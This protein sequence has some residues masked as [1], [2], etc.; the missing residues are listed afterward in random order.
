MD[1]KNL[2]ATVAPWIGTAL[3]GPLGGMAV[4]AVGNALGLSEKTESSIK[5]A[6]AGVTPDQMLAIKNADQA[7]ALQMQ[8]LGFKQVSDMEAFAVADRKD[9]RD[10]QKTTRSII[11]ATL[12]VM[13]T[14][15]YFGILIGMLSGKFSIS[16]SQALLIML[17]SLSTGWGV[18]MAFWFGTTN[19]SGRKTELLAKSAPVK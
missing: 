10:M 15:G 8:A 6:L 17:G 12:S 5:A 3:G 16:D 19:D 7:F 18:V 1:W 13:I 14:T 11:P 2:V 4:E 9:A